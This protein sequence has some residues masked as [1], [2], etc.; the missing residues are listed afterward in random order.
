[1]IV[2]KNNPQGY[3]EYVIYFIDFGFGEFITVIDFLENM[4]I[5]V[6]NFVDLYKDTIIFHLENTDT[7]YLLLHTV[8][9]WSEFEV[10]REN[11]DLPM[12]MYCSVTM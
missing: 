3:K 12:V 6:S 5:Y 7:S 2:P 1:M 9:Y 8:D 4:N 11:K 10:N